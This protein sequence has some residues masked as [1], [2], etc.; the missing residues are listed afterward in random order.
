MRKKTQVNHHLLILE[1]AP[2]I[3]NSP[4]IQYVTTSNV[5]MQPSIA[6]NLNRNTVVER[7]AGRARDLLTP[8]V[9]HRNST[10]RR[11]LKRIRTD[12]SNLLALN[13]L[14]KKKK[15]TQSD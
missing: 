4:L 14:G 12:A 11:W 1:A 13:S 6:L 8:G 15:K 5:P 7:S 3:L 2:V 9:Y 10:I